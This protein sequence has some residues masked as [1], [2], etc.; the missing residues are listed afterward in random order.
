MDRAR[1][2]EI[3]YGDEIQRRFRDVHTLA[4]HVMVGP[5]ALDMAARVLAGV[6]VDTTT[7]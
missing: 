5:V 3:R 7:L 1:R 4:Q 2:P 6:E